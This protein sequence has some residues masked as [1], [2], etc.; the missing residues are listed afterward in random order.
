MSLKKIRGNYD[1]SP[2]CPIYPEA[3]IALRRING[4]YWAISGHSAIHSI[5]WSARPSRDR[6]TVMPSDLA[7]LRLIINLTFAD[8]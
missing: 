3:D 7:V 1:T 8:S 5:T 2:R 4:G 6:G